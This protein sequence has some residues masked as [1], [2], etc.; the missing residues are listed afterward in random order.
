VSG[1]KKEEVSDEIE[2]VCLLR[3]PEDCWCDEGMF[4][5]NPVGHL[6]VVRWEDTTNIAAWQD[7]D[8]LRDFASNGGW[9]CENVGWVQMSNEDCVVLSARRTVKGEAQRGLTERIPRRA[10]ISIRR[11]DVIGRDPQSSR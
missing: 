7:M 11:A 6:A 4:A 3:H 5:T 10:I 9:L 8:D 1:E 2:Q